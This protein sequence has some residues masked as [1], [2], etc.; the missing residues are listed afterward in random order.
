MGKSGGRTV[1]PLATALAMS[2]A[3][4]LAACTGPGRGT[5]VSGRV[6][7]SPGCGVVRPGEPVCPNPP[8]AGEVQLKAAD[9]TIVARAHTNDQGRYRLTVAPGAYTLAV[10]PDGDGI[11]PHCT[12]SA[13]VI[14]AE[15][16]RH[17]VVCGSGIR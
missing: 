13:V 9:G 6:T 17:D 8:V 2:A 14:T 16:A 10:D 4:V 5:A 12:D 11:W 3:L 15:A 7:Q 1:A